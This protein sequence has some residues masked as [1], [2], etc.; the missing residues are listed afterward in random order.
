M[1]DPDDE[2]NSRCD[3]GT[4][5]S[6]QDVQV[7]RPGSV[8]FCHKPWLATRRQT[9]TLARTVGRRK[10]KPSLPLAPRKAGR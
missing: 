7:G 9:R 8:T 1:K 4:P 2:G 3:S 10:K 6:C 5:M